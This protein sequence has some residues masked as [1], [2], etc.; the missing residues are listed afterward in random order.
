MLCFYDFCQSFDKESAVNN[1]PWWKIA[2]CLVLLSMAAGCNSRILSVQE[3]F[4]LITVGQS[5]STEVLSLLG[6]EGM[7]HTADA[8]SVYKKRGWSRELGIV[9]FNAEDSLVKR[10]DYVQVRSSQTVPFLTTEKLYLMVQTIIPEEVLEQP[11]ESD[12][13]KHLAILE[14]CRDAIVSDV[15]PFTEDRDSESL[16][17]MAR[18]ALR[19][20]LVEISV[21]PRQAEKLLTEQGFDFTH[22]VMGKSRLRLVQ[23]KEDVFTLHLA[24]TDT[25]D[26]FNTW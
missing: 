14:H 17:G 1:M 6:E 19:E 13:R 26:P 23:D 21:R 10:K 5:N 2:G 24:C 8:V 15:K 12:M 22:T 3:H 20:A 9:L 25:V 18:S 11:Y 7:L 16:M 4:N